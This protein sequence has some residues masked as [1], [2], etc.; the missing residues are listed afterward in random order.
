[1]ILQLGFSW[2]VARRALLGLAGLSLIAAVT[3]LA[4]LSWHHLQVALDT[5]K[6]PLLPFSP[7]PL[8]EGPYFLS[9]V[10]T[11]PGFNRITMLN[12]WHDG[13]LVASQQDGVVWLL[14][15]A[16]PKASRTI[17]DLSA[18]TYSFGE[19]GLFGVLPHPQFSNP[20]ALGHRLVYV[21]YC[22]KRTATIMS[23]RLSQF[24]WDPVK[25]CL[26]A[27]SEIILIDQD[28]EHDWHNGGSMAFGNDGF[29]YLSL[30]DEGGT[31][32]VNENGQKIDGD[33]FSG[34]LRIDVD[35]QGG[36][37]SHPIIKQPLSGK[38]ARYFIPS[39]NP[40][41]GKIGALEEFYAIGL[42]SPHNLFK[43]SST[44][45][46]FVTDVGASTREELNLVSK[47]A[48][49]GW[50]WIEGE[51]PYEKGPFRGNRPEPF[52]G[53]NT[54]PLIAYPHSDGNICIIGGTFYSGNLFPKLQGKVLIGDL[55]SGRLWSWEMPREAV[56]PAQQEVVATIVSDQSRSL[57]GI[58]STGAGDVFVAT[59]RGELFRLASR[60]PIDRTNTLP[61]K[62]SETGLFR[63]LATLTPNPGIL[64]YEV[65]SALW[66]DGAEKQRWMA[67]P[68]DGTGKLKAERIIFSKRERWSFPVGSTFIKQFN[69][70]IDLDQPGKVKRLET[71]IIVRDTGGGIW[72][73][74]YRWNDDDSDAFLLPAEG[75]TEDI[76]VRKGQAID[77]TTSWTY[78]SREACLSC[79]T[80]A[81]GGILGLSTAQLNRSI[82][83]PETGR[84]G[85]QLR[86]L[87]AVGYFSR[88]DDTLKPIRAQ[89]FLT[90]PR[91]ASPTDTRASLQERATAYFSANC[92][93]CHRPGYLRLDMDLRHDVP[94]HDRALVGVDAE[95]TFHG[96][97]GGPGGHGG[98]A[99]RI[100]P[101]HPELSE[102]YLRMTNMT[103]GIHMPPVG[104]SVP[105]AAG[106]T[107][108][109]E[110]IRSLPAATATP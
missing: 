89:Q 54:P 81:T 12:P 44:G 108:I 87:N 92:S 18:R 75:L 50:S 97:P 30:G 10:E 39:D 57:V 13:G 33:L 11:P 65:N 106:I 103:P 42:R 53:I 28:D 26:D 46:I 20:K 58:A 104:T 86:S 93:H 25:N 110:W 45:N 83:Y 107:L 99:Q 19:S 88:E 24:S 17:L 43:D 72:G 55:G 109:E 62:L 74:T 85:D 7:Q 22:A 3:I 9:K 37:V 79:H 56:K 64:P 47:G 5:R 49:F 69:L 82:T 31:Y 76:V 14:D 68:G 63:D 1:M 41:C 66:S 94:L 61:Q 101:Q 27:G 60:E 105:D 15:L 40:W 100:Y 84:H 71:R 48:N 36:T 59:Y 96:G 51:V 67:I 77:H 102:V 6:A 23:N 95:A 4:Y 98:K 8:Q 52:L 78:P 73:V 90:M 70:P 35:C 16:N 91:M 32:D 80:G 38:T 21:F 29:L 2:T 34:V